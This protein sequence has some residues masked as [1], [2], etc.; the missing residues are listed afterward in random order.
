[1][2]GGKMSRLYVRHGKWCIEFRLIQGSYDIICHE[3]LTIANHAI[4][5]HQY[6]Q[7]V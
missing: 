2:S 6:L 1:M 4:H 5:L 7:S 3:S